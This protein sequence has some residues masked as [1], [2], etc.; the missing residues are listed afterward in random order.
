MN[1]KSKALV[2]LSIVLLAAVAGSL[3]FAAQSTV[4]AD[5][6]NSTDTNTTDTESTTVTADEDFVDSSFMISGKCMMG[7]EF[8]GGF[9]G[10]ERGG[11]GG[12]GQIQVSEEFQQKVTAI[13]EGDED[14]QQLLDDGYTVT[15][16]KPIIQTTI[17]GEGLVV[18]KAASAVLMLQ[19]GTVGRATVTVDI[20][21]SKVTQIV[22]MT[23]TVIEK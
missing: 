20:D 12:F 14:V 5:T 9:R 10:P 2:L 13:A 23:R 3:I 6:S 18:A 1:G 8:G 17:D 21:Q 7:R 16:I 11:F 19:N 15:A 22:I 4:L